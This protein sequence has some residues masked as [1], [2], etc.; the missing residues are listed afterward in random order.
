V[1]A[2]C[3]TV[4]ASPRGLDPTSEWLELSVGAL[5]LGTW[6]LL[7]LRQSRWYKRNGP[8]APRVAAGQ[9]ITFVLFSRLA[10]R[11]FSTVR[12]LKTVAFIWALGAPLLAIMYSG[13][14]VLA[15]PAR[16]GEVLLGYIPG[17]FFLAALLMLPSAISRVVH[18]AKCLRLVELGESATIRR[19][20]GAKQEIERASIDREGVV[21]LNA[22]HG[23]PRPLWLWNDEPG[24]T[25]RQAAA[26]VK[27]IN[28]HIRQA[29][30][31]GGPFRS[32]VA[33]QPIEDLLAEQEAQRELAAELAEAY[34]GDPE[35][36][37]ARSVK[38]RLVDA[39]AAK[40]ARVERR[41]RKTARRQARADRK[42]P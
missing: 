12:F 2:A 26:C 6:A 25:A 31:P 33:T 37:K 5:F 30:S 3:S 24:R 32:R 29:E 20:F 22:A 23:P 19:P 4:A 16:W 40:D 35:L 9:T 41:R 10:P 21:T 13:G 42:V 34:L 14:L 15:F 18:T 38:A 39:K 1:L 8:A 7:W 17:F 27:L 36:M 28:A 11:T